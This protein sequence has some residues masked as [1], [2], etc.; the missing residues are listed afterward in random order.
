MRW[1]EPFVL[2]S[3]SPRRQSMLREAG[4][5]VEVRPPDL[6][7]GELRSGRVR[8]EAWVTALAYLKARRVASLL[9]G[10]RTCFGARWDEAADPLDAP[11]T[12]LGADTV[13]VIEGE[14]L[15]QPRDEADARR[16]LHLLRNQE[17]RTLT[18]VCL[19][20]PAIRRR[21]FFHDATIVRVGSLG[22][23]EVERYL[24][25]G[26]WRG[27]AGAYN[28]SE[29]I[30]AGWPLTCEGDPATVMGLPMRRLRR[31]LDRES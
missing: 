31:I 26:G 13:C 17:H 9:R 27:K 14:I 24:A 28:L 25:S 3:R 18:G 5:A 21:A 19:L 29:R 12:V 7:D 16:M 22:D 11:G 10:E 4:F 15:G 23:S 2:A 8:P 30:E 6:D 20:A 1:N